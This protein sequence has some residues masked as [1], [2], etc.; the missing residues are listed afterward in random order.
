MNYIIAVFLLC[1][2][3]ECIAQTNKAKVA[4]FE[5][6]YEVMGAGEHTV[7]LEAGMARAMKD[8]DEVFGALSRFVRVIRYSR[9]GNGE[10][11]QI[12]R[13]FSAEE[14]AD[15]AQLLLKTL[16]INEPII[17]VSHSYGSIVGRA[18]AAK[19]PESVSA[20]LLVDPASENDLDIMRGMDL[21]K[22]VEEIAMLKKH[23][24]TP[25][26][27]NE[28]LDYWAKRPMPSFQEIGDI[29]VTLIASIKKWKSPPILLMT[30][31]GRELMGQ[32]YQAWVDNFPRGR[33]VL[34]ENSYHFIQ[35]DEP[36]LVLKEVQLLI[37]QL[38]PTKK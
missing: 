35:K 10:S 5:V 38:N 29:P 26:L 19:Y 2:G 3:T 27:A 11:A 34:T 15:H 13:H 9:V 30:D 7:L 16:D 4:E 32:H 21:E 33:A 17:Y 28:Y 31:K 23:G 12:K 24:D 37:E 6:A 1:L 36:D 18:F 8:W 14:Y 25:S 22:A 20:M